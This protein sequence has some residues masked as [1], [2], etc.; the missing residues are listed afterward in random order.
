[1]GALI[2]C[3]G[4]AFIVVS[5][6]VLLAE[7]YELEGIWALV[8][9]VICGSWVLTLPWKVRS[10]GEKTIFVILGVLSGAVL[11]VIGA[12]FMVVLASIIIYIIELLTESF[13]PIVGFGSVWAILSFI[14]WGY[15]KD[16]GKWKNINQSESATI[17]TIHVFVWLVLAIQYID[18]SEFNGYLQGVEGIIPSAMATL[19]TDSLMASM[20][21]IVDYYF[22]AHSLEQED[23][24][25]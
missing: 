9:V 8:V 21:I 18:F 2:G 25:R 6:G 22:L 19:T 17:V 10:L 12:I 16:Q 20:V 15:T 5:F 13:N 1:M 24:K 4:M 11:L 3:L 23:Q 14:V 7:H